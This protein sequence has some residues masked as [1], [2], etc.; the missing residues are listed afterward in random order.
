MCPERQRRWS[1]E[2]SPPSS[3]VK[4]CRW[5]KWEKFFLAFMG[6]L[7]NFSW[8]SFTRIEEQSGSEKMPSWIA[9]SKPLRSRHGNVLPRKIST[10]KDLHEG[11]NKFTSGRSP[12][13]NWRHVSHCFSASC[14]DLQIRFAYPLPVKRATDIARTPESHYWIGTWLTSSLLIWLSCSSHLKTFC[15]ECLQS[16]S[17]SMS[18]RSSCPRWLPSLLNQCHAAQCGTNFEHPHCFTKQSWPELSIENNQT[19]QAQTNMAVM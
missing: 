12:W 4:D 14:R 18:Q 11:T 1:T 2:E 3:S 8:I 6:K 13:F 16:G 19:A 7:L 9:E 15:L 17:R 5:H 10:K